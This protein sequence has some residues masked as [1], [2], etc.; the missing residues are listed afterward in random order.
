VVNNEDAGT[1]AKETTAPGSL[2]LFDRKGHVIWA[3]PPQ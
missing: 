1:G 2:T 3:A